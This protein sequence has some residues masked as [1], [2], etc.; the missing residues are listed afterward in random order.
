[1]RLRYAPNPPPIN[2]PEDEA[3]INA[4]IERRHPRGLTSLDLALL[5]SPPCAAGWNTF[6]GNIRT[7]TSLAADAREV[8][9]CRVAVITDAG[10]EWIHHAPLAL[11]AGVTEEGLGGVIDGTGRGLDDKL[12]S[13]LEYSGAMTSDV[14]V[15]KEIWA[16]V[17]K[18]FTEREMVELTLVIA[19]YN[20]T[21]RFL[22]ALDVGEM[23]DTPKEEWLR[24]DVK[25][26]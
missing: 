24:T 12:K 22:T 19:A 23:N 3:T 21:S 20:C 6:Y 7:R 25:H 13:V 4:I 17:R 10:Y 15:N 5:H 1:M 2:S 26:P 14:K 9:I 8:A 16:A 11:K 18:W